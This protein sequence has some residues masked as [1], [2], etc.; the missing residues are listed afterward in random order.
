MGSISEEVIYMTARMEQLEPT[1]ATTAPAQQFES[2]PPSLSE[3]K[4]ATTS[5]TD[6]AQSTVDQ[7]FGAPEIQNG[8]DVSG[9][10]SQAH[11]EA[12]MLDPDQLM[13][14]S[15]VGRLG[16]ALTGQGVDI[17]DQKAVQGYMEK[18][19]DQYVEKGLR[20]SGVDLP[21][22]PTAA[23]LGKALIGK[24]QG[25]QNQELKKSLEEN[26]A[27]GYKSMRKVY[28]DAMTQSLSDEKQRRGH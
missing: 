12:T 26:P 24:I 22:N 19:Y 3:I 27:E 23:D 18:S 14:A 7:A 13:G 8:S 10:G 20:L 1:Q 17:N 9:P 4:T 15:E 5:A 11:S 21:Q 6:K 25:G 16:D 28:I 2:S